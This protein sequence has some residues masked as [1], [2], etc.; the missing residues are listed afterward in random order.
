M[1][2][3]SISFER[4]VSHRMDIEQIDD[5]YAHTS[6]AASSIFVRSE[7]QSPESAASLSVEP[8]HSLVDATELSREW[9]LPNKQPINRVRTTTDSGMNTVSSTERNI[10]TV[11]QTDSENR[12]SNEILF[13][14]ENIVPSGTENSIELITTFII[15]SDEIPIFSE[16]NKRVSEQEIVYS[17]QESVLNEMSAIDKSGES[18]RIESEV[19]QAAYRP[20]L[21][22]TV[23][24]SAVASN[25]QMPSEAAVA[26][27]N[28]VIHRKRIVFQ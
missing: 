15:P 17:T 16:A 21:N 4:N 7:S 22:P 12:A 27:E 13:P 25:E 3:P 23:A 9:V 19:E 6:A 8:A 26:R 20:T 5:V 28:H 14:E 24:S 18:G 2:S 1:G 11:R 10:A